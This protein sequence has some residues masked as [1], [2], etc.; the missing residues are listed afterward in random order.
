MSIL[1]KYRAA[2]VGGCLAATI[3][4][5]A[6]G[7]LVMRST[8]PLQP[9]PARLTDRLERWARVAPNRTF[10]AKRDPALGGDWRRITYAQMLDLAQRV[11]QALATRPLSVD[12]PI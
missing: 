11:G 9:Y 5:K 7:V 1:A 8:E 10:V 12:R 3:E 4:E 2:R 6:G